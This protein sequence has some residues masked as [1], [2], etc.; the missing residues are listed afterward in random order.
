M[1]ED[2]LVVQSVCEVERKKIRGTSTRLG[3]QLF[4]VKLGRVL[5]DMQG[6][7]DE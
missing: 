1:A 6:W 4:V 2:H 3:F 5:E 7:G